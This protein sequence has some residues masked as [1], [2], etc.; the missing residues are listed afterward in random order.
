MSLV[1]RTRTQ[2]VTPVAALDWGELQLPGASRLRVALEWVALALVSA[3]LVPVGQKR[4]EEP[5]PG[6]LA[7]LRVELARA[8]LQ[9]LQPVA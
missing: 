9:K 2:P 5:E 7:N 8:E 6:E 3:E 4:A 1:V